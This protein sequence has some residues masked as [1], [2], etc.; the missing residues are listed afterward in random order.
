LNPII[1]IG[2]LKLGCIGILPL[3]EMLLDER[4]ERTDIDVIVIGS[5]AKLELEQCREITNLMIKQKPEI[6][7]LIGP[8]QRK[9]GAEEARKM[10]KSS[11][12]PVI[13]ISDGPTKKIALKMKEDGFGYII[14][15]ADSM[16][17]AKKE[18]LDPLEMA[19]YNADVIKVLAIAGVFN[20][21]VEEIDNIIL[22]LRSG[23]KPELPCIIVDGMKAI[24]AADFYNPYAKAK[25]L[26]SYE[27]AKQVSNI[28]TKA[29]FQTSDSME[30]MTLVT[31]GHEMMRIAA[32]LA[33]EAR[34]IEK[35]NDKLLRRPH[36]KDGS[37]RTKRKLM[38]KSK[39]ET[40]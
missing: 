2:V 9:V 23:N 25:A 5:G 37:L 18:F 24:E 34:E 29:C 28:T 33:D 19:I 1:K 8:A 40:I 31:E 7:I 21:I 12:I 4:A 32:K 36:S 17:G 20:L 15:N 3:F 38:E 39:K 16:L 22:S 27:I 35:Y 14:I 6:I 11:G 30:Y 10:L 26:A 13:V